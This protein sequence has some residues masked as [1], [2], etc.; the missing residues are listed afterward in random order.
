MKACEEEVTELGSM[1]HLQERKAKLNEELKDNR[2][3]IRSCEVSNVRAV[4]VVSRMLTRCTRATS[5]P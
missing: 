3:N 2:K 1:A 4:I 5:S